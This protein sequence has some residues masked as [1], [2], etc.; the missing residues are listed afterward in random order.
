MTM[1]TDT[2]AMYTARRSHDKNATPRE[3]VSEGNENSRQ[4]LACVLR[5]LAQWS[6]ASDVLFA[7]SNGPHRGR[8]VKTQRS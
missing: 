5:S 4:L 7:K 1:A 3:H 6:L 2:M 8:S